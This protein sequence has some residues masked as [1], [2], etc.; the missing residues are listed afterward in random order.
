MKSI[1]IVLMSFFLVSCSSKSAL[2]YFDKSDIEAKA[3]QESKKGDYL[4]NGT[5]KVILWATYLNNVDEKKYR[6][7]EQFLVSIYTSNS[8]TQSLRDLSYDFNLNSKGAFYIE[9]LNKDNEMLKLISKNNWGE[10]YLIMFQKEQ[11]DNLKLELTKDS[12]SIIDLSFV[13]VQ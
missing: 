13:K 11:N 9:K 2:E 5:P 7:N 1:L 3:F 6:K 4:E 8:Q 12:K 10:Y